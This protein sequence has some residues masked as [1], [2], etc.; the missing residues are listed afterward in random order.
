MK[1]FIVGIAG[2]SGSGKTT[3]SRRVVEE[4]RKIGIPGQIFSLDSYYRPLNHLS[5]SRRKAY[6]FDHPEAIDFDL[7][8]KHLKSLAQGRRVEQPVYDFTTH[9]RKKQT[10]SMDPS[11]LIVVE[12]LYALYQ[13]RFLNLYHC[14]LFVSTGIATAVLRRIARDIVER[15]RDV[16]SVKHQILSTVLPMYET[17]VKPTQKNAHFSIDWDGEEV[18]EKATEGLV[19]M[20]RDFF[21]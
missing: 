20:V 7:A 21:R 9:T 8:L 18:P 11:P 14:R 10:L 17:F 4:C 13:P 19:R 1:R 6:N 15:G 16:D 2:G 3:L 5:L 12:G